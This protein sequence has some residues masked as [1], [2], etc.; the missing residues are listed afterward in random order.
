LVQ[1]LDYDWH[2]WGELE[3]RSDLVHG[4]QEAFE[5][6]D[7]RRLTQASVTAALGGSV[8][9]VS[10]DDVGNI[11]HKTDVGSYVYEDGR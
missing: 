10:Y 3:Q 4:Q 2:P 8:V 7:L 6:D 1:S 9:D 5:H 11:T